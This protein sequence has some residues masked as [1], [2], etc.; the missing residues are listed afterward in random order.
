[1]P[2]AVHT[3]ARLPRLDVRRAILASRNESDVVAFKAGEFGRE[4]LAFGDDHD[5]DAWAWLVTAEQ[6]SRTPFRAIPDNRAAKL[7]GRRDPE[8]AHGKTRVQEKHRHEA[9]PQLEPLLIDPLEVRPTSDPLAGL[10]RLSAS[11]VQAHSSPAA[12]AVGVRKPSSVSG[13]WRDGA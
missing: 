8:P 9:A 11:F 5:I 2:I 7:S 4:E 13:P 6:L 3:P 1:M 10:E 12:P